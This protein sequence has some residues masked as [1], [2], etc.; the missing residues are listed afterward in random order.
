MFKVNNRSIRHFSGVFMLTLYIWH[1][2]I[3]LFVFV[4]VVVVADFENEMP[5]GI[6]YCFNL[7]LS[8]CFRVGP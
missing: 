5:D 8:N 1:I 3:V 6:V 7:N 4:V 2:V